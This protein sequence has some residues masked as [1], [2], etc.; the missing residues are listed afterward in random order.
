[1]AF[2]QPK[3]DHCDTCEGYLQALRRNPGDAA[4]KAAIDEHLHR[5]KAILNFGHEAREALSGLRDGSLHLSFLSSDPIGR[6]FFPSIPLPRQTSAHYYTRRI[7]CHR[8]AI[9]THDAS[10]INEIEATTFVYSELEGWEVF[11]PL[12]LH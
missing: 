10:N 9:V 5:A 4:V 12:S 3:S 6:T 8:L 7:G 1:V 2:L 11:E